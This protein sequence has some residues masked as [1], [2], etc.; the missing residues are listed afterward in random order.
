MEPKRLTGLRKRQQIKQANRTMFL[1]VVGASIVVAF[2]LVGA[3]FLLKQALFNGKVIGAKSEASKTLKSNLATVDKLKS[4]VNSL[5]ANKNLAEVKS[6]PESSNH[7]VVLDALPTEDD[8]TAF[9]TSL[10]KAILNRSGV[11]IESLTVGSPGTLAGEEEE[12]VADSEEPAVMPFSLVLTGSYQQVNAALKDMERSIR[13]VTFQTLTVQ[14]SDVQMRVT[15]EGNT[16]YL[17]AKS[18]KVTQKTIKP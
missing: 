16:Y 11:G 14:G 18:V 12:V 3:Q 1:W 6:T 4:E 7:Q 13:P 2:C 9:A 10:Q 15:A 17:P 8:P 5:L